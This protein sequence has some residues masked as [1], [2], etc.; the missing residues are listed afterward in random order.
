[1]RLQSPA[2]RAAESP[3]ATAA[4]LR[5]AAGMAARGGCWFEIGALLFVLMV[6]IPI[7]VIGADKVFR[8]L[9]TKLHG[10]GRNTVMIFLMSLVIL[11]LLRPYI[12]D[13]RFTWIGF[14]GVLAP[15]AALGCSC[16]LASVYERRQWLRQWLT[17]TSIGV[18][19]SPALFLMNYERSRLKETTVDAA[20]PA[21]NPVP[22]VFLI[23][24]EFSG[25]TLVNDQLEI[26]S[27]R[28]PQFARLAGISTWYRNATTVSPRTEFAIPAILSG[29]FPVV[30][31][32]A[33][34]AEYPGNLL[35][36]I[37]ATRSF[38][39]VVFEPVTRL[40]PESVIHRRIPEHSVKKKCWDLFA[41]LVT[42]YPRL[43]LSS[44]TPVWFPEIPRQWFGVPSEEDLLA[45]IIETKTGLIRYPGSE[46][47]DHQQ[48]HFLS[49]LSPSETPRF[50]FFHTV[51][52]HYPW[53]FLASGEQYLS[54]FATRPYPLGAR[55]GLGENWDN[56]PPT[57]IRNEFRYRQQVGYVDRF[58]GQVLDR[59]ESAGL[60][61][62]CLLIVTADHGVSF[63]P[64]HSRRLPDADNLSDILS[65]PLFVKLP[66]QLTGA[67]DDR[68]IESVDLMPTI[69]Q[70]I[71]IPLPEPIDGSSALCEARRPRKTLYY[72][73]AMTVC[74]PDVRG[75]VDSIR[76]Q[77]QLYGTKEL[78]SMPASA[79]SHSDWHGRSIADFIVDERTIP[80]ELHDSF[81]RDMESEFSSD[82][83]IV[84][85]FISG[86]FD[87]QEFS[88]SPV[89]IVLTIDGI[90]R[91]TSKTTLVSY[92]GHGF[93]F[94]ITESMAPGSV[95]KVEL[96][97]VDSKPSEV[98]LR[99]I[100]VEDRDPQE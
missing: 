22:I 17:L 38:E 74:E 52:P 24:D 65:V 55:G 23:F 32:P 25:N 71:G 64:G 35:Q 43:I 12:P 78:D 2:A 100:K 1:M 5:G 26:D 66:G 56:D 67:T 91:D 16:L 8:L 60:L 49:F 70:V 45:K 31:H 93:E 75:R 72:Q 58:I 82:S 44:D 97:V 85:R 6:V 96:F 54:E 61:E 83:T 11:S 30:E 76:R 95:G 37:E 84:P 81:G 14:T 69:A 51:L 15:A 90:V 10:R 48:K 46:G 27:R 33:T 57:V 7:G 68:N 77:Q 42:V 41:A 21:K 63:H 87:A 62:R 79:A 40:C 80:V 50:C 94:L 99:R 28:F 59:L 3:W 88:N 19:L 18:I 9:S 98:R 34:A 89:E 20:V 4:R 36:L 13:N 53:T 39:M 92:Q 29:R 73:G 86:I 47:R